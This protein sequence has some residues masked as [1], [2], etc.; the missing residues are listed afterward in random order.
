MGILYSSEMSD[1][2]F[3]LEWPLYFQH[4]DSLCGD[5]MIL[6][7]WSYCHSKNTYTDEIIFLYEIRH[8]FLKQDGLGTAFSLRQNN[9]LRKTVSIWEMPQY[10]LITNLSILINIIIIND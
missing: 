2:L 3:S 10:A 9:I 4:M 6:L 1:N 8:Q 5:K 7:W